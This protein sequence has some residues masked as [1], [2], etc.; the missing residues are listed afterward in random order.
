MERSMERGRV[1][2]RLLGAV[3]L[4]TNALEEMKAAFAGLAQY[5]MPPADK[6]G[7]NVDEALKWLKARE[8]L[9]EIQNEIAELAEGKVRPPHGDFTVTITPTTPPPPT[10]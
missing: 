1:E 4:T 3:G 9:V 10:L 7:L 2:N 6:G 8:R 5:F